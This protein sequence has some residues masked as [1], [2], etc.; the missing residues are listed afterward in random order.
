MA[1]SRTRDIGN[2]LARGVS[3]WQPAKREQGRGIRAFRGPA[4]AALGFQ[5]IPKLYRT[6]LPAHRRVIAV[7]ACW[8]S[9]L[10][11]YVSVAAVPHSN[12][13]EICASRGSW[14]PNPPRTS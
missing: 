3:P 9:Q 13:V 11:C 14:K 1:P 12:S 7:I 5:A 6:P 4:S 10:G 2:I 8:C